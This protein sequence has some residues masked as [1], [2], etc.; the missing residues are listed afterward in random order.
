L[1]LGTVGLAKTDVFDNMWI[2][3]DVTV[4]GTVT[5]GDLD[6]VGNFTVDATTILFDASTSIYSYSPNM[7]FGLD[8]DDWMN[9]ATA[10]DSGNL[11]ITHDGSPSVTWTATGGFTFAGGIT[12]IGTIAAGTWQGTAV[13]VGYGGT[14]SANAT[15]ARSALGLIIGTNVQAWDADLDT[16][17]TLTPTANAQTLVEST[18]FASMAQ[19][20]S[21]EIGVDTQAYDADLDTFATLTPTA[22]AQTL[23]ESTNFASMAQDLSLEI[24]VDTQAYDADLDYL[25]GFT[26]TADV[27]TIL[28]AANNAA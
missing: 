11:T 8:G 20:L 12:S 5:F 23:L 16:W 22:N 7:R 28:N 21:L 10:V 4:E 17:A 26:L 3:G 15:D 13:A 1:F 24:G 14:G 19:D 9:F 18:N 27:K 6:I 2:G 25:S